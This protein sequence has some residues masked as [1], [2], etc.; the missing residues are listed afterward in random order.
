VKDYV[1]VATQTNSGQYH[2]QMVGLIYFIQACKDFV[3]AANHLDA[4]K[5]TL[6]YG[7]KLYNIETNFNWGGV[8]LDGIQGSVPPDVM[9]AVVGI[10]TEA[11]E[12]IQ[13]VLDAINGVVM[14]RSKEV[15][16]VNLKEESGDVLWYLALLFK[17]L[18][19]DFETEGR[20]NLAKLL[21][22]Y[23]D[24][25]TQHN[26]LTRDIQAERTLLEQEA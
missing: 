22:R 18:D 14:G 25:F 15:D 6:F 12:L 23:P 21:L 20:R 2:G 9:H 7:R 3:E 17:A 4:I 26:A 24:G 11:G 5:K 19:T 10:A 13:N 8:N 16:V 1:Q